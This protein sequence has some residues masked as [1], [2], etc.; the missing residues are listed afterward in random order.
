MAKTVKAEEKKVVITGEL[1]KARR[2]SKEFKGRKQPEKFHL[3]LANV[4]LTEEQKEIVKGAFVSS[5]E[6]FTPTW[7]KEM[8]GYVNLSTT[9][10]IPVK[11]VDGYTENSL[12]KAIE[13]G[14]AFMHAKVKVSLSV[15]QG[16]IYPKAVMVLEEGQSYDAFADFD[17]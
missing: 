1:I 13:N 11:H 2:E 12:E 7:V 17:C 3:S 15:K 9:Y 4:E 8:N 16:A 10:D 6:N 14:F 5:G